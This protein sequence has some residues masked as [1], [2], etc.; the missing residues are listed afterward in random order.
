MNTTKDP[1]SDVQVRPGVATVP[2]SEGGASGSGI[3][4][5]ADGSQGDVGLPRPIN[6]TT[7]HSSPLLAVL[8]GVDAG[9]VLGAADAVGR[10]D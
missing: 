3:G 1:T 5:G 4:L 10:Q 9:P 8:F 2:D 6:P 7:P